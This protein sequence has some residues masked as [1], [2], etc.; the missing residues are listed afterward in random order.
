M[1]NIPQDKLGTVR[2]TVGLI[3]VR[4]PSRSPDAPEGALSWIV[5]DVGGADAHTPSDVV[6]ELH[7]WPVVHEP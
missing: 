4:V 6:E 7:L 2:A 5:I 3:A 1:D